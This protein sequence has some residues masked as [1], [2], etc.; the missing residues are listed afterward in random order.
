M[1]SLGVEYLIKVKM[2]KL[3]GDDSKCVMCNIP[4]LG[5]QATS[6]LI[7]FR[8][9]MQTSYRKR[10]ETESFPSTLQQENGI[11]YVST[12]KSV[13]KK[14]RFCCPHYNRKTA[15]SYVSTLENVFRKA[16]FSLYT[17][18]QENGIFES[19]HSGER[20]RKAPLWRAFSM[21]ED[22]GLVWTKGLTISKSICFQKKTDQCGLDLS[23]HSIIHH[24]H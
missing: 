2:V 12:L 3:P 18:Q 6:T 23:V 10:I 4:P 9:K 22:A 11:L 20:F 13:F 14:L 24:K 19:I 17:P 7:H 15:F 5:I 21:T 8:L 16:P 1:L